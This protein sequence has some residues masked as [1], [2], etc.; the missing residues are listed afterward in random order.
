MQLRL[1]SR[2]IGCALKSIAPNNAGSTAKL[3]ALVHYRAGDESVLVNLNAAHS[4]LASA[5]GSMPGSVL[6]D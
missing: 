1:G 4:A 6:I 3:D 2:Q 5:F